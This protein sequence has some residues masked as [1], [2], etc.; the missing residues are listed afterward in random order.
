MKSTAWMDDANC[1][2]KDE[3]FFAERGATGTYRTKHQADEVAKQLCNACPVTNECFEY[4]RQMELE[5][6]FIYGFWA[7]MTE[8]ERKR[9]YRN[10]K[11]RALAS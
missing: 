6:G 3:V 8:Q 4:V 11:M 5:S 10:R 7:G 2:G 9:A 1:H